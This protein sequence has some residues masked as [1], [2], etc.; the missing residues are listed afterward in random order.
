[1]NSYTIEDEHTELGKVLSYFT[2]RTNTI[3]PP[4]KWPV[5]SEWSDADPF[6]GYRPPYTQET[7]KHTALSSIAKEM[8]KDIGGDPTTVLE[9]K[10][11]DEI[12]ET[13]KNT[14]TRLFPEYMKHIMEGYATE[15][16]ARVCNWRRA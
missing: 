14:M 6:I 1:M 11:A 16:I 4:I 7:Y 13:S 5:I 10:P 8:Y 15:G 12:F 3:N 9:C 2:G